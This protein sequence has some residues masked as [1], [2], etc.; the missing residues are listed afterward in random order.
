VIIDWLEVGNWL[1]FKVNKGSKWRPQEN[2]SSSL[3][4][5]KSDIVTQNCEK[6]SQFE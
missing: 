4:K 3:A 2:S 6:D 5:F 1:T